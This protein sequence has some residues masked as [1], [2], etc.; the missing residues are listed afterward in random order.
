MGEF[1]TTTAPSAPG[2]KAPWVSAMG[3]SSRAATA[4]KVD[5][6]ENARLDRFCRQGSPQNLANAT[7]SPSSTREPLGSTIAPGLSRG[8]HKRAATRAVLLE[9]RDSPFGVHGVRTLTTRL[10]SAFFPPRRA[11]GPPCTRLP[12]TRWSRAGPP[13]RSPDPAHRPHRTYVHALVDATQ[14]R[15]HPSIRSPT[16]AS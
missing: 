10:S 8:H 15:R 3:F 13:L 16:S 5:A 1:P 9:P 11:P 4:A 2:C 12:G 14:S 7:S 6:N